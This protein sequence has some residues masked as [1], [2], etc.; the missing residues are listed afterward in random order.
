LPF[1]AAR[2]YLRRSLLSGPLDGGK[3][4]LIQ[5]K[6]RNTKFMIFC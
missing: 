5:E 3:K 2:I 6:H 4:N 1:V